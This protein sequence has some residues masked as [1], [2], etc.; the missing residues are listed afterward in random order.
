MNRLTWLYIIW[1]IGMV[2][3]GGVASRA[4]KSRETLIAIYH[5]GT[6]PLL[7]SALFGAHG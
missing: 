2:P 5:G 1:A 6:A 3:I 7:L 4:L